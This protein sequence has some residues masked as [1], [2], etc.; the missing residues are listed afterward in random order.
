HTG[1]A[2]PP[3]SPLFPYTPLFRSQQLLT[4]RLA[5]AADCATLKLPAQ[6]R[7]LCPT[8]AEQQA[9]GPDG[10]EHLGRSPLHT[11]PVPPGARDDLRSEEHTSELQSLRHLVCRLLL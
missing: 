10:L 11:A 1:S 9:L 7:P 2:P 3:R 8:P 5:A 6:V 4:G